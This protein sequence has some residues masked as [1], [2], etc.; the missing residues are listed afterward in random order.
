MYNVEDVS[1]FTMKTSP[2]VSSPHFQ[3]ILHGDASGVGMY[4]GMIRNQAVTLISE[5]FTSTEVTKSSTYREVRVFWSFYM[6]TNLV[7][8]MN[9]SIL[10]YTDNKSAEHILTFGSRNPE[11]EV[12]IYDI[13]IK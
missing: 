5:L 13:V 1:G 6:K 8:F 7:P 12:M 11:I 10:Q 3:N 9:S 4:L 2:M